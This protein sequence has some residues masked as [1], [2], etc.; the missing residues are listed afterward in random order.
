MKLFYRYN[1]EL[2]FHTGLNL[3]Y[4]RSRDS[5]NELT[6]FQATDLK[7][8]ADYRYLSSFGRFSVGTE[9][10]LSLV[11][12]EPNTEDVI[13][14][15]GVNEFYTYLSYSKN[16]SNRIGVLLETGYTYRDGGRSSLMNYKAETQLISMPIILALGVEGYQSV[17]DDEYINTSTGRSSTTNS[18]NA[19]SLHFYSV[20]PSKLDLNAWIS[21][22]FTESFATRLGFRNSLSGES[23]SKAQ[24]FF[25]NLYYSWGK[26]NYSIEELGITGFER[27]EEGEFQII[28]DRYIEEE[29]FNEAKKELRYKKKR[30]FKRKKRRKKIKSIEDDL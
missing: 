8:G 9:L 13:A 22:S 12:I 21:Y 15:E 14:S 24:S 5:I 2:R 11:S 7:L 30:R 10:N 16:F 17:T 28:P 18:V 19:G 6:N 1:R 25:F 3:N 20:N 26:G 29:Y 4:A 23:T 27:S